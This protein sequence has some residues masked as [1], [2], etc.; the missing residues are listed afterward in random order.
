MYEKL[1]EWYLRYQDKP[2]AKDY[3]RKAVEAG[4]ITPEQYKTI[5][6]EDY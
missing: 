4:K 3:I 6:G 2:F 1:R 5:T